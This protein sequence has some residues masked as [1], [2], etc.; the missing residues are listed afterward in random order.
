[1]KPQRNRSP[2]P[3]ATSGAAAEIGIP[4]LEAWQMPQARSNSRT[5]AEI[6][7][8]KP[9]GA[10]GHSSRSVSRATVLPRIASAMEN[11]APIKPALAASHR[12]LEAG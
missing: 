9:Q 2:K 3:P 11:A 8:Q 5:P 1:M 7:H 4:D 10:V 6:T 12:S